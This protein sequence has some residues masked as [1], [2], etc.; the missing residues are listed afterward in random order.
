VSS[1]SLSMGS[2]FSVI[3]EPSAGEISF[4][5]GGD[6][7][8]QSAEPH[9]QEKPGFGSKKPNPDCKAEGVGFE[10]TRD[11]TAPNGF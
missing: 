4:P 3:K 8:S 10:P 7:W 5:P 1:P 2:A 6:F 11:L 9:E